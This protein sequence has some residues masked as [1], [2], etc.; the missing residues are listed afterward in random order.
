MGAMSNG[1]KRRKTEL[2]LD[3]M[4]KASD[5]LS[6]GEE[7]TV[8]CPQCQEPLVASQSELEGGTTTVWH[9]PSC[10]YVYLKRS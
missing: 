5:K 3:Q 2:R 1:R 8:D 4:A 9:C 6:E 10:G 7:Q